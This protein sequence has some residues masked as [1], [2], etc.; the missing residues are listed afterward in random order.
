MSNH[1]TLTLKSSF[2]SGSPTAYSRSGQDDRDEDPTAYSRSGQDYSVDET[3]QA[4]SKSEEELIAEGRSTPQAKLDKT[5]SVSLN[6]PTVKSIVDSAIAS[7][8]MISRDFPNKGVALELT[9]QY[10]QKMKQIYNR[11]QEKQEFFESIY[12]WAGYVWDVGAFVVGFIG[13]SFGGA[14]GGK[15]AVIAWKWLESVAETQYGEHLDDLQLALEEGI[16][17]EDIL[18]Q[19][20]TIGG[21]EEAYE[22]TYE[23]V[24]TIPENN[25]QSLLQEQTQRLKLMK[26][27]SQFTPVGMWTVA[28]KIGYFFALTTLELNIAAICSRLRIGDPSVPSPTVNTDPYFPGGMQDEKPDDDEWNFQPHESDGDKK[29]SLIPLLIGGAALA[30]LLL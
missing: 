15:V 30:T 4:Y 27:A 13:G 28:Y 26:K 10:M 23:Y 16:A 24:M 14:I 6:T 9:N 8:C 22:A 17:S 25:L 29:S 12:E 5:T 20:G 18:A 3:P 7:K 2:D 11:A 21:S 1:L 19:L